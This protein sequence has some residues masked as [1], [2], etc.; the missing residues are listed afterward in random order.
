MSDA[1]FVVL[2]WALIIYAIYLMV[3]KE[4]ARRRFEVALESAHNENV[5]DLAAADAELLSFI[6][7]AE[8][9]LARADKNQKRLYME[10]RK[11][12]LRASVAELNLASTK[13]K[14]SVEQAAHEELK[15]AH[16]FLWERTTA[17]FM[18]ASMEDKPV[19]N[20]VALLN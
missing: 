1:A 11:K 9:L 14:L 7:E 5:K 8:E 16:V 13:R 6:S 2:T 19:R 20:A 10:L 18:S 15:T 3:S 17:L 12:S 4:K